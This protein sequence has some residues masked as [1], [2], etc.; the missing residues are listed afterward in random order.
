MVLLGQS[1][2]GKST[3]ASALL[4]KPAADDGRGDQKSDFALG[5][6]FADVRDD[7]DEGKRVVNHRAH[8]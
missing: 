3:L 5:Y 4:Q 1:S 6:D 8:T 7:G 2:S